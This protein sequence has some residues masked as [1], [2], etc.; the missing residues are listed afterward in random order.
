MDTA[1]RVL[2]LVREAVPTRTVFDNKLPPVEM[3]PQ[4]FLVV[5][6]TPGLREAG[7][8][9][10]VADRQEVTWQVTSIATSDDPRQ[11]NDLSWQARWAAERVR[12]HLV[13]SRLVPSGSHIRH[14]L[15]TTQ[16]DND[17]LVTTQAA[18]VVDHYQARA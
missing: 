16:G 4:E 2:E 3:R 13:A 9:G 12:D 15:S 5:Y 8:I 6:V 1:E 11:V 18:A 7:N 10:E 17:Q 14:T